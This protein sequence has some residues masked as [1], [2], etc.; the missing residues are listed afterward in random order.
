MNAEFDSTWYAL[1]V[2]TGVCMSWV[3]RTAWS[4]FWIEYEESVE[5]RARELAKTKFAEFAGIKK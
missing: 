4:Q 3:V 5:R 1:G 2:F